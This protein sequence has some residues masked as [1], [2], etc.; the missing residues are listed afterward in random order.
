MYPKAYIEYLVH[1]H[2]DRD[3]FECH[4]ILEE[5]WKLDERKARKDHW[6]GLIQVAV[7]L[8]HQRRQ[9]FAGA[10]RMMKSA[11]SI[12]EREADYIQKLGLDYKPLL[13]LLKQRLCELELKQPYT[14]INLPLSDS[15]LEEECMRLCTAKGMCW[16]SDSDLSNTFLLNK[17][18][19][20]D[21]ANIIAEREL[22]IEKR[23]QR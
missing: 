20:R 8:Y 12:L 5:H 1:F 2:G 15:S 16:K 18:T 3:Y 21:R 9:N 23:K 14:S 22:Q 6:V 4:E 11:L 19:L 10:V 17:H 7:S 13:L